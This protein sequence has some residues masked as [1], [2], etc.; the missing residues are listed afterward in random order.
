VG[1]PWLA[2]VLDNPVMLREFR[3]RMRGNRTYVL[4]LA[5]VVMLTLVVGMTYLEWLATRQLAGGGPTSPVG[6][7]AGRRMFVWVFT[8]QAILIALITPALTSG[9]LTIEREQRSYEMLVLSR[10]R[11][12]E[13][14]WG[15]LAAALAFVALLLTSSLPLVSLSFFFGGV[16]P[17]ELFFTYLTLG[18]AAFAYGAMGILWSALVPRTASATVLAYSSVFCVALATAF[19]GVIG[20]SGLVF[21][22]LNP[23]TAV[24]NAV[25]METFYRWQIPSWLNAAVLNCLAGTLLTA[26]A[27]RRLEQFVGASAATARVAATLLWTAFLL[28]LFGSIV[29]STG[30][31]WAAAGKAREVAVNLLGV[32]LGGLCLVAPIFATGDLEL[33]RGESAVRRFLG[34]MLP[35][36]MWRDDL[37]AGV[38]LV[39]LWVAVALLL[40]PLSFALVGRSWLIPFASTILPGATVMIACVVAVLAL[41]SL[42]SV[43]LPSRWAA[44]TMTYLSL[45]ALLLLPLLGL[46]S[47]QSALTGRANPALAW[48]FLYFVPIMAYTELIDPS[49]FGLNMPPMLF[50]GVPFWVVT[51]ILHALLA[52]TAATLCLLLLQA[53]SR[54]VEAGA[55]AP[56]LALDQSGAAA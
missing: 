39:G 30:V 54:R 3:S 7:A 40:V 1:A 45:V 25:E 53:R 5:Y 49:R 32:A 27:A 33:R 42:Y 43:L 10:L 20:S 56:E 24:F 8:V 26:L 4:L 35:H 2:A 31:N 52:T 46:V 37:P 55:A 16:S 23:I 19:P 47:W 34:G 13:V 17:G 41:G 29:G 9:A 51:T 18:L 22:S 12:F 28:L 50:E 36:R 11:P 15:K 48:Q 38:P 21:R 44:L 14:V 6:W